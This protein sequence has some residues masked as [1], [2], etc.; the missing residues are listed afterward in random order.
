MH[1]QRPRYGLLTVPG[2][3]RSAPREPARPRAVNAARALAACGGAAGLLLAALLGLGPGL[4]LVGGD[5]G[6]SA[7]AVLLSGLGLYDPGLTGAEAVTRVGAGVTVLFGYGAV[8]L[9]LAGVLGRPGPALLWAAAGFQLLCAAR[10]AAALPEAGPAT[11]AVALFL[12]YSCV[13][14]ALLVPVAPRPPG[15]RPTT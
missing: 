10:A 11:P 4:S 12:L 15:D 13:M 14:L 2:G 9:L 3:V 8:S 7:G 1:L 6:T 5:G